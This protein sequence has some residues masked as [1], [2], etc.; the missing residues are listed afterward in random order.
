MLVRLL[1]I[2][3]HIYEKECIFLPESSAFATRGKAA[4]E[5]NDQ[6]TTCQSINILCLYS[7]TLYYTLYYRY[8]T[9]LHNTLQHF[10]SQYLTAL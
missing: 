10:T 6:V 1:K 8:S 2:N 5:K 7:T 3:R 4:K 9:I